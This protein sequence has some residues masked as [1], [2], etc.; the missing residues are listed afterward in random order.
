[1]SQPALDLLEEIRRLMELKGENVFKIRAFEKAIQN[2]AG[3]DDLKERAKAGTL[4]ELPGIGKGIS[5]V[6]AEFLLH[7]KSTARDE[8]A[9]SL[10]AGLLE[11][12]EIP[13]LGPKKAMKV[14]EEL[15]IHS[16]SELEYAC[17]ENRLLKL[18]GF[19]EKLQHKIMEGIQFKKSTQGRQLLVDAFPIAEKVFQILRTEA[20]NLKY[21]EAGALRRRCEILS[22][23]DYLVELPETGAKDFQSR[24]EKK[25]GDYVSA[26]IHSIQVKIHFAPARFFGF[27]LARL[28]GSD[29]H[30]QALGAPEFFAA[31]SEQEFYSKLGYAQVPPPETRENG[32]ELKLLKNGGLELL[33]P[34]DGVK[35]IFHNHTTR[36]DGTATLE[37][38][39]IAA[40]KLGYSYI[41]VSDHSQSA[42]YAQ[43]LKVD[44]LLEQ[45]KEIRA[46]QEKHP[47]IRIFWGIESDILADGSLDYDAKTLR[48]FDFVVASVHSRFQMDRETMTQRILEAIRNPCTRFLGHVTGR[49][50]LGRKGYDVDME[51]IILEASRCN[52]AIELNSHPSR[53]DIDWRFGSELRKQGTLI[54]INPD[55]HDTEGLEDVKYGIAMSRKALIP[56]H[57]IVNSHNVSHVEKWLKRV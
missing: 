23:L 33:L 36:S 37:E 3:Q 20:G 4:T 50:L 5:E 51:K 40:K 13:G 10:P 29:A 30:W 15:D 31:V 2:L 32:E 25:I 26:Y 42:F 6:L 27:E 52:V 39:V 55:A 21:S 48:R 38:M 57:L 43:G 45:E 44:S 16:V 34:W 46:V 8:L 19:G 35:G 18:S 47:E 54:S 7:G 9:S 11:L 56:T 24:L 1:M 53:L 41:G 22:Q 12:C 14:I 17:C 49:L 28:S